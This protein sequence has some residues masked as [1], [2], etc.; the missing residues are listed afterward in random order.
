MS[1]SR[2]LRFALLP[3]A[4]AV[5]ACANDATAPATDIDA[6]AFAAGNSAFTDDFNNWQSGRWSAEEHPLG[7]GWFRSENV[8]VGG[9]ILRLTSPAGTT[10]GGEIASIDRFGNGTF[11]ASMRCG[12][13]AG[14]LCAFFLYQGVPGNQNDEIDF[15]VISGT[16]TLW[17]TTW[18]RGVETNHAEV[19]LPFDPAGAFHEYTIDYQRRSGRP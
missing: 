16:N 1:R 18:S 15:E 4:L 14:T 7:K 5:S 6:L 12:M 10:D 19:T 9:G 11:T 13:P 3:F 2:Y 8:S 17:M